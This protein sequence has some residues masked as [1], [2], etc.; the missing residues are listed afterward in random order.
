M[1]VNNVGGG[2]VPYEPEEPEVPEGII[3]CDPDGTMSIGGLP[4]ESDR[5]GYVGRHPPFG[6]DPGC[7]DP[8][9]PR[10]PGIDGEPLPVP[11]EGGFPFPEG[12]PIGIGHPPLIGQGKDGCDPLGGGVKD[13]FGGIPPGFKDPKPVRPEV[14]DWDQRP[15]LPTS[16]SPP[17]PP[18]EWEP[19]VFQPP[20]PYPPV[21]TFPDPPFP[22]PNTV[23][24]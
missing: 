15:H 21:G 5:G 9:P 19:P 6:L 12:D 17:N 4:T 18:P 20:D 22:D 23:V 24:D 7:V 8:A 13:P 14:D 11:P 3:S 10:F 2:F 1:G 16:A